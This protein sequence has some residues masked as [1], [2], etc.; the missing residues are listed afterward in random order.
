MSQTKKNN[1]KLVPLKGEGTIIIPTKVLDQIKYLCTKISDVEWSGVLYHSSTGDLNNIAEFVCTCEYIL[2][3]DKGTSG[4]TSFVLGDDFNT[5]IIKKPELLDWNMSHVHSHHSMSSFFSGTDNEELTDNAPNYNYYLSLIINNTGQYVAK[6]AFV[7]TIVGRTTKFKGKD[8]NIFTFNNTDEEVVFT[9]DMNIKVENNCTVDSFFSKQVDLICTPKISNQPWLNEVN[10]TNRPEWNPKTSQ[11]EKKTKKS[12]QSLNSTHNLFTK[13]NSKEMDIEAIMAL[14]QILA[15]ESK[16]SLKMILQDLEVIL[17]T[18]YTTDLEDNLS[19]AFLQILEDYTEI[20]KG[21]KRF[22][23][24]PI[25]E[26]FYRMLILL[27]SSDYDAFEITFYIKNI[28]EE[29]LK[30]LTVPNYGQSN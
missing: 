13:D 7:G 4:F 21:D 23:K 19:I 9:Y 16:Q 15:P 11:F 10:Y 29:T 26:L 18:D 5:A 2:P 25:D 28:I 3:L 30:D 12:K 8:G 6:V 20:Q 17:R 22:R 14:K 24:I 1:L 27:E